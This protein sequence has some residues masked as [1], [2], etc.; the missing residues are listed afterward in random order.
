LIG[1]AGFR[2]LSDNLGLGE[3]RPDGWQ[4]M[5][6]LVLVVIVGLTGVGKSTM[7]ARLESRL[8]G[9]RVL[10]D[11][12]QLTD[13]VIFP[14]YRGAQAVTDRID[15]FALTRRFRDEHPGGMAEVL[16]SLAVAPAR[17]GPRLIF[18]G[19]RGEEEVTCAARLLPRARFVA[20][21]APDFVRLNRL[22]E[23]GDPFDRAG[24]V[25]SDAREATDALAGAAGLL[26][27]VETERLRQMI[28]ERVVVAAD[29]KAKLAIVREER[30][31]Y[32]PDRT[33]AALMAA[34]PERSLVIDTAAHAIDA[35]AE[36]AAAF[37][38]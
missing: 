9:A 12:R 13:Q 38:G 28:A 36:R 5:R 27:T 31:S 26:S 30:R 21:T 8:E 20:L 24:A 22:L 18:D 19:L 11:R 1:A 17:P 4:A 23:R 32:D 10:P 33:I 25:P 6:E 16:A 3:P 35:V 7:V 29:V 2:R 37:I 34:A 14:L 15:R